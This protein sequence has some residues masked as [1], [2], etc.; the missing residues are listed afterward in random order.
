MSAEPREVVRV[1]CEA[2]AAQE[3][4][5]IVASLAPD[6]IWYGTRGGLDE[7]SELHG[8]GEIVA[9]LH[10]VGEAW[11]ELRIEVEDIRADGDTVVVYWRETGR[12]VHSELEVQND[13]TLV[14]QVRDGKVVQGRAYMDRE[15]GLAAAG[16]RR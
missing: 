16:L 6:A 3:D 15:E 9:Y 7:R 2:I 4:A 8:P 11:E 10:D 1:M 13:I 14:F 12:N 5:T